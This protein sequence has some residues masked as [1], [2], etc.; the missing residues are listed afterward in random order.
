MKKLLFIIFF[1]PAA[2]SAQDI[3]GLYVNSANNIE[4]NVILE[5]EGL[6]VS[7]I[8]DKTKWWMLK[9]EGRQ[10]ISTLK[11]DMEDFFILTKGACDGCVS[12]DPFALAMNVNMDYTVD[13][14][15]KPGRM[16]IVMTNFDAGR[17]DLRAIIFRKSGEKRDRDNEQAMVVNN[18][19]MK[20]IAAI[21][22]SVRDFVK[23]GAIVEGNW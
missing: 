7:D 1:L 3:L 22:K 10:Y 9:G 11:G 14:E 17:V 18:D 23:D 16:R 15:I 5:F 13:F 6:S 12:Y 4:Y 2:C 8:Y 21:V 20:H 19:M